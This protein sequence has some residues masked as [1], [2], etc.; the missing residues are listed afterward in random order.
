MKQLRNKVTLS[1]ILLVGPILIQR[2][3]MNELN[4]FKDIK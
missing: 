4:E 1:Q 2:Y 3:K